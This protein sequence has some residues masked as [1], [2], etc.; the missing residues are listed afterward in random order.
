MASDSISF[1]QALKQDNPVVIA[2]MGTT[3]SGKSTFI[4]KATGSE[5]KIIGHNLASCKLYLNLV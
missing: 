5:E 3:G 1:N 2:I 4:Q